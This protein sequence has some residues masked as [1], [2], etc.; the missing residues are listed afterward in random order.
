MVNE[1]QVAK[2]SK[3][4]HEIINSWNNFTISIAPQR[5]KGFGTAIYAITEKPFVPDPLLNDVVNK[6]HVLEGHIDQVKSKIALFSI[7]NS[8]PKGLQQDI[9]KATQGA[10]GHLFPDTNS[11]IID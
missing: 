5:P 2:D 3:T 11:D 10:L 9:Y 4:K 7:V 1:W 6:V 8:Y